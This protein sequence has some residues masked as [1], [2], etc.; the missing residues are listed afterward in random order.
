MAVQQGSHL[1]EEI[2]KVILELQK[3]RYFET[4][5]GKDY[6]KIDIIKLSYFNMF[7]R[8][9]LEI[10]VLILSLLLTRKILEQYSEKL[11]SSS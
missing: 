6:K 7:L 8:N 11:V 3:D 4:L 9:K 5:S 1:Q 10:K 2:S